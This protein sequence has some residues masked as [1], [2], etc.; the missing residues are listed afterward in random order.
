MRGI[1][2]AVAASML[3]ISN[4]QGYGL[5]DLAVRPRKPSAQALP[6]IPPDASSEQLWRELQK[7]EGFTGFSTD[8]QT[9]SPIDRAVQVGLRSLAWLAH[10]NASRPADQQLSYTSK[11]TTGGIPIDKPSEYSPVIVG[12]RLDKIQSEIPS[13]L[14]AVLFSGQSFP[15]VLP[16]PDP[17]F[18][19]WGLKLDKVYQTA[20]RWRLMENWLSWLAQNRAKDVRGYYF[21]NLLTEA[22]REARL[23]DVRRLSEADRT[24]V[25]DWVVQLCMNSRGAT[26]ACQA[27]VAGAFQRDGDLRSI[28]KENWASAER[29]Y[30]GF[31]AIPAGAVRGDVNF[32]NPIQTILPFLNPGRADVLD[33]LRDNIEDEWKFGPWRLTLDFT[34]Q[35]RARV[36]FVS[37]ATPHVNG[38]G[39]DIITMNADQPLTEYDAQ[40]TIR[41][42][43][44]HVLGLPDCYVEF[45]EEDRGVIVTYQ[46]DI[47]NLMCSR[48]GH[49]QERHVDELRR[50]YSPTPVT[51]H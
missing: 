35:A 19:D 31:F 38:L 30:R 18:I 22:E 41:H 17:E 46:I 21:L 26:S 4:A 5:E 11:A 45:Y 1:L 24:Q 34:S 32:Q 27:D 44:G 6:D 43:F 47:D 16:V 3:F 49:I 7:L 12:D 25:M 14:G 13:A 39:G 36:E 10:V 48:H 42:E 15:T 20:L 51:Q 8:P 23:Q 28:Y 37:G 29:L 2:T 40:W 33:F 9:T 50:V